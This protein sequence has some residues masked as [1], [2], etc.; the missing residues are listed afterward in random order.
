MTGVGAG[1]GVLYGNGVGVGVTNCGMICPRDG[2]RPRIG[3]RLGAA[4]PEG[5]TERGLEREVEV[6]AHNNEE[7]RIRRKT[8]TKRMMT[9]RQNFRSL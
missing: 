9:K 3:G 5:L 7:L 2:K 1:R 8:K 4:L 6:C